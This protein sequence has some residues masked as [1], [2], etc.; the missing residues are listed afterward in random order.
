[1]F[2]KK[3]VHI[4][5]FLHYLKAK[6]AKRCCQHRVSKY[7]ISAFFEILFWYILSV[8]AKKNKIK[9]GQNFATFFNG[10]GGTSTMIVHPHEGYPHDP[11]GKGV[12]WVPINL[13][14]DKIKN[15]KKMT[16]LK[17][18]I[19]FFKKTQFFKKNTFSH[20]FI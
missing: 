18:K 14:V 10:S 7:N 8:T 6:W 19:I 20:F 13:G 5:Y 4:F 9:K 11:N 3:K 12:A 17:K 1:M 15:E 16:F 2:F